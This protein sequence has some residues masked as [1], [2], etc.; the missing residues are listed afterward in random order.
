M[1]VVT[2]VDVLMQIIAAANDVISSINSA[3]SSLGSND[4]VVIASATAMLEQKSAALENATNL[5]EAAVPSSQIFSV[6]ASNGTISMKDS[7]SGKSTV[8]IRDLFLVKAMTLSPDGQSLYVCVFNSDIV[9]YYLDP[10]TG[11]WKKNPGFSYKPLEDV[12]PGGLIVIGNYL[13]L[14]NNSRNSNCINVVDAATG[15]VLL[16]PSTN[17]INYPL[18]SGL[19]T[20]TAI[21]SDGTHLY[22]ANTGEFNSGNT[23]SR[24]N[25]DGSDLKL[26]WVKGKNDDKNINKHLSGPTQMAILG[27]SLYVVN[28]EVEQNDNTV[29]EIDI[30]DKDMP[31]IVG[32]LKNLDGSVQSFKKAIG[33][34]VVDNVLN[35]IDRTG[36]TLFK[37][38]Y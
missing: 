26:E 24:M 15:K 2:E 16:N 31:K 21:I 3:T 33:L 18:A 8:I 25:I 32:P 13:Y 4:A 23:I 5:L 9:A 34:V 27:S 20:P 1:T 17:F 38:K 14:T 35:I 28:S 6:D 29:V 36:N 12:Y 22:V 10:L 11:S 19:N 7:V 37:H 30:K